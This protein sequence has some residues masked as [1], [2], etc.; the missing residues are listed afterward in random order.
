MVARVLGV[1]GLISAG[2]LAF[3][4]FTSNPFDRLLPA[5]ADGRDL[6]PLLQDPGMVFHPPM[7]YMGYVGFS[8]AFC[9]RG[10]GA[11][12]RPARRRLGALV[13]ALDHGGLVLPHARHRARQRL[14]LLRARLGRLVVLGPGGERLL[15]ALAGRHRADPLA[16]GD[17]EARR[18]PQLDGA[19]RDR[20]LR[21]SACSAPSSCARACSPRCTPSRSIRSAA[22][23]SSALFAFFI[24][25]AL[26][27]YAW[28]TSRIG[29]GG[30]FEPVSRECFL[31]ANNVLLA[32]AAGTV[33][34]GTLYPL[35]H[36][37]ASAPAR[38]RS[39]RRTS[40]RCSRRSWRRRCS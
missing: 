37:R 11:A 17:R 26:A 19:A 32:A 18:V 6:N 1:M 13:A 33:F 9:L 7:L 34:L 36:R 21:A 10:R 4:L 23:S 8:V 16:R 3:M 31:L 28:R 39:G 15:H 5:A 40:R 38:S 27:L 29:L 35:A 20:R 14:G 25:G 2:F 30:G 12:L 24:G 22:S